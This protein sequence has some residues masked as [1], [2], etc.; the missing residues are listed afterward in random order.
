MLLSVSDIINDSFR[1]VNGVFVHTDIS[2]DSIIY[3]YIKKEYFKEM[4]QHQQLYVAN[5]A[6]FSD[7]R[8]KQ[9]KENLKMR[10]IITPAFPSQD[11]I[12]YYRKL[13]NKINEAYTLCISC[14]T[15]DKHNGCDESITNW[16]CYGEDTYR[17]ETTIE[18]LIWSIHPTIKPIII[19]PISYEKSEYNG[20]VFNAIFKKYISYQDEQELRLCLLSSSYCERLDVDTERLIHKVRLSPFLSTEQNRK[21]KEELE[22]EFESLSTLVELSH[23]YEELSSNSNSSSESSTT[24][25]IK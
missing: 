17:I 18:D 20:T 22:S 23:L 13:V 12:R 2:L 14:W 16:K 19:S 10:Y 11:E 3:K 21:E 24:S 25:K 7:R 9:W 8:E 5:R 4:M 1:V 15:F 6:S